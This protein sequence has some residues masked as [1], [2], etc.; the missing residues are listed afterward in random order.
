MSDFV[1]HAACL[2]C[3]STD[4]RALYEGGTSYCFVC[5]KFFN[6]ESE[7]TSEV[8]P[9]TMFGEF[10]SGMYSSLPDRQITKE[11][12][13]MYGYQVGLKNG[14]PVHIANYRN[15]TGQIVAQKI[16]TLPKTFSWVGTSDNIGLYGQQ[17]W[18]SGKRIVICE[19]EIDTLSVAQSLGLTW[20]VVGIPN[21]AQSASKIIKANLRY[22]DRFEE[23]VLCFDN[24]APGQEAALECAQILPPGKAKI[25]S[26][27]ESFKDANELICAHKT[28][29]LVNALW[30]ATLYRPEGILD[31]KEI[32]Y[33]LTTSVIKW[34]ETYTLPILDSK[35]CGILPRQII[36]FV[37]GTGLGKSTL[38][39]Q[40][41]HNLLKKGKKVAFIMLEESVEETVAFL[42]GLEVKR[43][44]NIPDPN[45]ERTILTENDLPGAMEL[46]DGKAFFCDHQGNIA[47]DNLIEVVRYFALAHNCE[48]IVI[49][50][51]SM[52]CASLTHDERKLIDITMTKLRKTV[53]ALNI[54]VLAVSQL[55]R[56]DGAKG[57]EDGETVRLGHLR[58]S[59]TI[60]QVSNVVIS[61]EG[62]PQESAN[63]RQVRL[64]KNRKRGGL[65]GDADQMIY[66]SDTGLLKPFFIKAICRNNQRLD[67]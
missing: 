27:P 2:E 17:L 47:D 1:K 8:K 21:G 13:Q 6:S 51:I 16:R 24:D 63:F 66:D 55:K 58:G 41:A 5:S 44:L 32:I 53:E 45:E 20:P 37:G 60:A 59:G 36:T 39:R 22:F 62:N 25:V 29:Q 40:I 50:H 56:L 18:G 34:G 48:Y 43:L 52:A 15:E 31:A 42:Y 38:V 67:V 12:C 19:G 4:G 7:S 57:H 61:V 10:I 54:T 64:L 30:R 28:D 14:K 11:T 9:E 26:L 46:L 33:R 23:I 3:P 65:V 49:D 35:T